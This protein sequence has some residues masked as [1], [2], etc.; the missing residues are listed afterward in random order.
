MTL[1]W[2]FRTQGPKS[3]EL[4]TNYSNIIFL[5]GKKV[6]KYMIY[7]IE[8]YLE[9]LDYEKINT[10]LELHYYDE[11]TQELMGINNN[12]YSKKNIRPSKQINKIKHK[13]DIFI[14]NVENMLYT[15][16][17]DTRPINVNKKYND[18][19]MLFDDFSSHRSLKYDSDGP[20]YSDEDDDYDGDEYSLQNYYNEQ[21]VYNYSAQNRHQI[22]VNNHEKK[23]NKNE[24]KKINLLIT[25]KKRPVKNENKRCEK[26]SMKNT[27]RNLLKYK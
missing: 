3:S 21:R 5:I 17:I 8:S 13:E 20:Y 23:N 22:N 15:C 12:R 27:C 6:S 1:L 26:N 2:K 24:L 10:A 16:T 14:K 4:K 11:D 18:Y 9:P 19:K 25:S 7:E